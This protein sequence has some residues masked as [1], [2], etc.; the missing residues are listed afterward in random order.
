MPKIYLEKCQDLFKY[1][2]WGEIREMMK[3]DLRRGYCQDGRLPCDLCDC[4]L[5]LTRTPKRISRLVQSYGNQIKF[6]YSDTPIR[7]KGIKKIIYTEAPSYP[8]NFD[9]TKTCTKCG[10]CTGIY[11]PFDWDSL[12]NDFPEDFTT[13]EMMVYSRDG[14]TDE[15]V[16]PYSVK[17]FKKVA[18]RVKEKIASVT[19]LTK[20]LI[21]KH[22][23]T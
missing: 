1:V 11:H 10:K 18:F 5:D 8:C 20:A 12:N 7:T 4:F 21:C 3:C 14:I 9:E 13:E 17:G 23:G 15:Y 2:T 19:Q 22:R 16:L 6:T